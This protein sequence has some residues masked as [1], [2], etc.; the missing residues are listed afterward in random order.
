MV[1][2]ENWNDL[3]IKPKFNQVVLVKLDDDTTTLGQLDDDENRTC[4][5]IKGSGGLFWRSF[6]K[7]VVNW[8]EMTEQEL[9]EYNK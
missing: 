2:E 5:L 8:R 9:K 1:M 7:T 3:E 6:V 4:W